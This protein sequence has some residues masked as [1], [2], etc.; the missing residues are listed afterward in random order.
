M[1]EPG[2]AGDRRPP[3][4]T[5]L[6]DEH[7]A[8]GARFVD[9]AGWSM[10][11]RYASDVAEHHAVRTA[12]GVFDLS[13]MGEVE[14]AGA[15]A[16]EALDR[17]L[18]GQL[19]ALRVGGARYSMVCAADGGVLDDLVV[20]R[21]DPERFLVVANAANVE[22]VAAAL[23][24]RAAGSGA[25]VTDASADW[26][27]VAV[28]GPRAAALLADVVGG[29]G[30]S[31]DPLRYY[32]WSPGRLAGAEVL[33]ART[34]YTGEDG[35]EVFVAS[36][37]AVDVWRAVLA[38]GPA[39]GLTAC[40]LGARDTLRLEA[41]M[42]LY[43]HELTRDVT[44]YDAGL[45]RVVKLGKP[46]D[47]VG[48]DALERRAAQRGERTLV[49]LVAAGR[50][51]PRTGHRVLDPAGSPV[52]VVTSGAPSPTLGHPVAMAYVHPDRAEAG[53]R[54]AVDVRGNPQDVEV[55]A[56]PFYRRPA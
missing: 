54:L 27:L 51:S 2:P 14:V 52:G 20:Y 25:T 6:H 5:P 4:R 38:A 7:A 34:G 53:A 12:V 23:A 24:E 1:A 49:G 55:T 50:R 17:A 13:H 18:V 11:V 47:F 42:P 32:S 45:A 48:R 46:V 40:G 41:G 8:L 39:H 35:F 56:L 10:P 36:D 21:L 33:L 43:G 44:P 28:Q 37:R 19:S 3:R 22:V 31:V 30:A 15:G 29:G 26:A 9:F 16:A